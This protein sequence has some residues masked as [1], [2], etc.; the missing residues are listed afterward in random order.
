MPAG[1]ECCWLL[2]PCWMPL[3]CCGAAR[4]LPARGCRRRTF[5]PHCLSCRRWLIHSRDRKLGMTIAMETKGRGAC[6]SEKTK[7]NSCQLAIDIFLEVTHRGDGPWAR[8][9]WWSMDHSVTPLL[10]LTLILIFKE[11]PLYNFNLDGWTRTDNAPDKLG[12]SSFVVFF[13][14]CRFGGRN[15]DQILLRLKEVTCIRH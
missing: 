10:C 5:V 12:I 8:F 9:L 2:A 1:D 7:Q 4:F 15:T 14:F 13:F 6:C 3:V 11:N